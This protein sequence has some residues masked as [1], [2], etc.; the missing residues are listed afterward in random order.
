MYKHKHMVT[1]RSPPQYRMVVKRFSSGALFFWMLLYLTQITDTL[2]PFILT[3]LCSICAC[4]FCLKL[5]ST[6]Y[7][8]SKNVSQIR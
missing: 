6:E 8:K 7:A 1:V 3:T 2:F 4:V 5:P